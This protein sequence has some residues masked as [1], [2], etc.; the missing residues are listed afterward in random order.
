MNV[1]KQTSASGG[2]KERVVPSTCKREKCWYGIKNGSTSIRIDNEIETFALYA[3]FDHEII[4]SLD[5]P[6]APRSGWSAFTLELRIGRSTVRPFI[7]FT[8]TH[9]GTNPTSSWFGSMFRF[10]LLFFPRRPRIV[11]A[12]DDRREREISLTTRHQP[13]SNDSKMLR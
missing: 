4:V 10:E 12:R 1:Q 7:G 3:K 8:N 11:E 5:G 9:A 6:V 13:S 2:W